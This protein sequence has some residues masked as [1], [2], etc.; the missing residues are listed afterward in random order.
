MRHN[1]EKPGSFKDG[2]EP[3]D[4][5]GMILAAKSETIV[6]EHDPHNRA[7]Y[8]PQRVVVYY[9]PRAKSRSKQTPKSE[10]ESAEEVIE[11]SAT[12]SAE[13]SEPPG[14]GKNKGHKKQPMPDTTS[15]HARSRSPTGNNDKG[16]KKGS[17]DKGR[18]RSRTC[19]GQ[20]PQEPHQQWP[21][22]TYDPEG[23]ALKRKARRGKNSHRSTGA[24][25]WRSERREE[26]KLQRLRRCDCQ[27][28]S[29]MQM[30]ALR[31]E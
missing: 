6:P 3:T 23:Y 30:D 22:W 28:G 19:R 21:T 1:Q 14:K 17:K 10:E 16:S 24:L 20:G 29:Y 12:D 11:N 13:E 7:H 31:Q 25:A 5:G 18:G 4:R 2:P 9:T 26:V 8:R 27:P 15:R